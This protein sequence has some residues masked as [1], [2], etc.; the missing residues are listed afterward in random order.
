MNTLYWSIVSGLIGLAWLLII[1]PLW[2]KKAVQEAGAEQRNARIAQAKARDLK[3]QLHERVLTQQQF[4]EQYAELELALSDDLALSDARDRAEQ[5]RSNS[6][7]G[8]WII[9]LLVLFIPLFSLATYFAVGEP[10]ALAKS[11]QLAAQLATQQT[12]AKLVQTLAERLKQTPDNAEGWVMLG[13]SYQQLKKYQLAVDAFAKA[14]ALLGDEPE[15]MLHYAQALALT[16]NGSL[17]GKAAELVF[18]SLTLAPDNA[19]GLW[20]AGMAKAEAGKFSS[21]L[22]YWQ[23]LATLLPPA[24]AALQKLQSIIAS[25]QAQIPSV[26]TLEP[27][28]TTTQQLTVHV[29]TSSTIAATA[30]PDATVFIYASALGGSPMPLAIVSKRVSELPITVTLDDSTAMLPNMKLSHFK[31][32]KLTARISKSASAKPQAGDYVGTLELTERAGN[33]AVTVIINREIE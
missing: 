10:K 20:L 19:T 7:Q 1:P 30:S 14:H 27:L 33:S 2:K 18:Q 11:E 29:R 16:N 13:R 4:D 31:A 6:W 9:P 24:S 17:T 28:P 5:T 8:R 21:A 26:A 23:K 12:I 25:A 22:Q 15:L 32:V 3:R